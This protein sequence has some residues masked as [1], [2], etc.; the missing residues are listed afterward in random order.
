MAG[1]NTARYKVGVVWQ[2]CSAR[3]KVGAGWQLGTQPGIK[4]ELCGRY[5]QPGIKWELG[6]R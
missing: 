2:V 4:W 5:V 1:R 6:G 3:Y